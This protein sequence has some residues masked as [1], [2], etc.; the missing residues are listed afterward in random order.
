LI[1][2]RSCWVR[3][4]GAAVESARD[5]RTPTPYPFTLWTSGRWNFM[6]QLQDGHTRHG[7]DATPAKPLST[8]TCGA[9]CCDAAPERTSRQRTMEVVP[10]DGEIMRRHVRCRVACSARPMR[11]DLK[12]DRPPSRDKQVFMP[13]PDGF[14]LPAC[15]TLQESQLQRHDRILATTAN[16]T[17]ST[18]LSSMLSS[19]WY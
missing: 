9:I 4:E 16:P 1:G 19:R 10:A 14:S 3:V 2:R 6:S 12:H 18:R 5:S 15:T 8:L 13:H 11:H 17:L 7:S